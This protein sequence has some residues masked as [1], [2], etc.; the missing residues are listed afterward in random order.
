MSAA[1]GSRSASDHASL[2]HK[3]KFETGVLPATS[4]LEKLLAETHSINF[5]NLSLSL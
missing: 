3:E 5:L 4:V 1:R 2:F